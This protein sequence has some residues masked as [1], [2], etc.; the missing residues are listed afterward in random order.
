MV[1]H[2]CNVCGKEYNNDDK[3]KAVDDNTQVYINVATK[4]DD[5]YT[6]DEQLC[7]LCKIKLCLEVKDES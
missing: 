2:F 3:I 6:W 1:K 4:T 7:W 5:T